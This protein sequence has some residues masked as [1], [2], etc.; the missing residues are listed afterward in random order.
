[1]PIDADAFHSRRNC[2]TSTSAPA[3]NV[4]TMPANEP[5]KSGQL[6]TERLNALPTTTPANSSISATESPSSTEIVDA[7]RIVAASKA[8]TAML[9]ISTSGERERQGVEA[10]SG[11]VPAVGREP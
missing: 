4:R 5:M 6:G 10:I 8:A 1:M 11:N 2:G 3:R 7:T 9:L